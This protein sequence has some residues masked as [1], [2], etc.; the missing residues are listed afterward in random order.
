[1]ISSLITTKC[2]VFKTVFGFDSQ[3]PGESPSWEWLSVRKE[4]FYCVSAKNHKDL[5]FGIFQKELFSLLKQFDIIIIF[6]SIG[7]DGSLK[8]KFPGRHALLW[9]ASKST[10]F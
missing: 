1:M 8:Y 2:N 10:Y 7:D 6:F 5:V 3:T 9:W 4:V